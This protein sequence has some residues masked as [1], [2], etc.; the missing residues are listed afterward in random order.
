MSITDAELRR[1]KARGYSPLVDGMD[2]TAAS[3]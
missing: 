3:T 2:A 1:K